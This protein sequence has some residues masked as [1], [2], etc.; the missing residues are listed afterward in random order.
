MKKGKECVRSE[1]AEEWRET[2]K[3][4]KNKEEKKDRITRR[5]S[6]EKVR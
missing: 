2:E 3:R 6:A 1:G 4:K 5:K